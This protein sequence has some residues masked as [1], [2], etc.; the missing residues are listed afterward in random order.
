MPWDGYNFEDA[1]LISE[2][3]ISDNVYTS[4]HIAKFTAN[5]CC[6]ALGL[7]EVTKYLPGIAGSKTCHLTD[8]GF[9]SIETW[10]NSYDILVGKIT[11]FDLETL[12]PFQ[13][14][15][16]SVMG[17]KSWHTTAT[18]FRLPVGQDGVIVNIKIF[19]AILE[20][21]EIDIPKVSHAS[22]RVCLAQQKIIHAGDKVAGRHGNKGVISKILPMED[23]PH[24]LYGTV[25]DMIL[26]PMGVPSRMNVGQVYECL[27]GWAEDTLGLRFKISPFDEGYGVNA[28][29]NLVYTKMAQASLFLCQNFSDTT[30]GKT[31]LWDG[32]TGL[33]F[34][35]TITVGKAYFLKLIHLARRKLHARST[36]PYALLTQQPL[37]G[38]R[39]NGG[40]RFG[41]ME[42]WALQAYGAAY[43][44][45]ELLTIKSDDLLGRKKTIKAL[46]QSF[47]IPKPDIT[48][49]FRTMVRELQALCLDIAGYYKRNHDSYLDVE[50]NL[51][52]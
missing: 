42:V 52:Q 39:K 2:R 41:E 19:K 38:R 23:V 1:V 45:H 50:V 8:E 17:I 32:R 7:E 11:P 26:N 20:P 25:I 48:E 15:L 10:V 47:P 6:T 21:W 3:L 9:V 4:M 37:R 22:I 40:Q 34:H 12:S 18:P 44:L 13:R 33:A 30:P 35:S 27:L 46:L 14:L 43:T 36:G 16:K 49:M 24:L 29:Y 28:S 5:I 31:F 51:F